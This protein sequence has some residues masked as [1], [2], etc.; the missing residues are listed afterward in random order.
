MRDFPPEDVDFVSLSAKDDPSHRPFFR[1]VPSTFAKK[2]AI[3]FAPNTPVTN[4]L[5]DDMVGLHGAACAGVKAVAAATLAV[6]ARIANTFE[7]ASELTGTGI[8]MEQAN[9]E[10]VVGLP[11]SSDALAPAAA[12]VTNTTMTHGG[13]TTNNITQL[14]NA[15]PQSN[16]LTMENVMDLSN[17][18]S[19]DNPLVGVLGEKMG[20]LWDV[21]IEHGSES[22]RIEREH[23]RQV[24]ELN[25]ANH[26]RQLDDEQRERD[27]ELHHKEKMHKMERHVYTAEACSR[28]GAMDRDT[29][30]T[31]KGRLLAVDA[32]E[33]ADTM[34]ASVKTVV[35]R[36]AV[37]QTAVDHYVSLFPEDA[38]LT[39]T[40]KKALRDRVL[41]A[42]ARSF[43]RH[44]V[45]NADADKVRDGRTY[46][47]RYDADQLQALHGEFV[48]FHAERERG[49]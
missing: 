39:P 6:N 20:A 44:V 18:I 29:V 36:A 31:L 22:A 12:N 30:K 46:V 41:G 7:Q 40:Q 47:H 1:A 27:A 15:A 35:A 16:A 3:R 43:S 17:R 8:T 23:K 38:S 5:L 21:V 10:P 49:S 37:K 19:K 11:A 34:P 42:F 25:V 4:A 33:L 32:P 26:K 45:S 13:N 14:Y 9:A 48:A 24:N 2:F 28:A